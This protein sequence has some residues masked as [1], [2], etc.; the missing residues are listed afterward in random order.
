MNFEGNIHVFGDHIDTDVIIPAKDLSQ[1][2]PKVLA[3]KCFEPVADNF[4]A[5]VRSGDFLFVGE[6]FGCGS[7]REHAP[8][9]IQAMGIS[10]IVAKSFARIYYRSAI[11]IGLP[12]VTSPSAVDAARQGEHAQANLEEGWVVVAGQRYP[13]PPYPHEVLGIIQAG[14]LVNHMKRR[15]L[16]QAQG[17]IA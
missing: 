1:S 11:N 7:S 2:D 16:A 10:C 5:R 17:A 4:H 15:L 8:I 6:N 13:V 12:V 3:S 9:A 14:G